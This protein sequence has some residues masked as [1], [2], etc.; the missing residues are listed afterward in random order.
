MVTNFLKN[1]EKADI[2]SV[3]EEIV[4]YT[5][6]SHHGFHLVDN[7]YDAYLK[8]QSEYIYICVFCGV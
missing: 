2:L 8:H 6:L 7:V 1:A 3:Q 5:Y 4:L